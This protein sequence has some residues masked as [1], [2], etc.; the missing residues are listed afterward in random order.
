VISDGQ[1]KTEHESDLKN[2]RL[3]PVP[4]SQLG[5]ALALMQEAAGIGTKV[6]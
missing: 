2:G 1:L 4:A 5:G 3:T 6:V